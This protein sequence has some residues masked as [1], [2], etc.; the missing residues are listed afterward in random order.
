M[1]T[2]PFLDQVTF[3]IKTFERPEHMRRLMRSIQKY[4]RG[5]KVII[6]DDG[7]DRLEEMWM[8]GLDI[9]VLDC[10]YD[11]G[12][13]KGR[14]MLVAACKTPYCIMLDDDYEMMNSNV[15][16]ESFSRLAEEGL[17]L[18]AV[19]LWNT[20]KN[21]V[22]CICQNVRIEG[23]AI[24]QTRIPLIGLTIADMVNNCFIADT[25]SLRLSGWDN[26]FKIAGEHTD[27]AI[28]CYNQTLACGIIDL[29]GVFHHQGGSP[30]YKK[31]R[32]RSHA[33][34]LLSKY[35]CTKLVQANGKV[36]N[37][38]PGVDYLEH[39]RKHGYTPYSR[40]A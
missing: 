25:A 24:V 8:D 33:S 2:D 9:T 16:R 19:T 38:K 12:L 22:D 10:D 35:G 20:K 7:S 6:V 21:D 30:K 36:L 29:G 34:L 32:N 27:F 5:A 13:S 37:I 18:L 11:I 26:V 28:T 14:N 17:D 31:S 15:W 40:S 39:C 23:N 3:L 4:Y 1:E